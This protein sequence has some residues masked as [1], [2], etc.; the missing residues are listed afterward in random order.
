MEDGLYVESFEGRVT[1]TG[2]S[3]TCNKD[4]GISAWEGAVVAV[5]KER[6]TVVSGNRGSDYDLQAGS[7]IENVA[8]EKI[9]RH[10]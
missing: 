10:E 8:A 7:A 5:S 3:V 4:D 6:P 1:L 9:N 2:G